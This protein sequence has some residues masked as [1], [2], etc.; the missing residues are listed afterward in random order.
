MRGSGDG[1][2]PRSAGALGQFQDDFARALVDPDGDAALPRALAALVGQPG[3]AVYRNTTIKACVDALQANYP[4]VARIVG[5][6]WFRAAAAVHARADLPREPMLL[7][8]GEGF[9]RFLAEFP[10][11]AEL[12]YL[13]GVAR[14]DRYWGEA[15]AASDEDPLTGEDVDAH[16]AGEAGAMALRPHAAA[17]WAWFDAQPIYTIWA[18]NRASGPYDDSEFDWRGEGAL[19]VRPRDTV[20]WF[21]LGA[22][23]CAFLDACAAGKTLGAAFDAARAA[24]PGCDADALLRMLASAGALSRGR[25]DPKGAER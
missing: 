20:R 18:R 16:S 5:E 12:S 8:Y 7:R 23:G 22:D 2:L 17:R 21:R 3:F 24:A 15:H 6:E 14:L 11:A 4:A 9:E 10:P 19:I 13:P 1:A 25:R